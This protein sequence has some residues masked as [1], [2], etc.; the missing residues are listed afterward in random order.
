MEK[1]KSMSIETLQSKSPNLQFQGNFLSCGA[2]V[3]ERTGAKKLFQ[4]SKIVGNPK[5]IHSGKLT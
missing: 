1:W 3:V 5:K 4:C 2:S